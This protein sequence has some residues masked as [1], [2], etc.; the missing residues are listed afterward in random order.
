[1]RM[2]KSTNKGR[3]RPLTLVGGRRGV[4]LVYTSSNAA[5]QNAPCTKFLSYFRIVA[6]IS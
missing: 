5:A 2:L 4:K 6:S 1:M 3:E